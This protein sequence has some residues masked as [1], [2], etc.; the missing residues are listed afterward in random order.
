MARRIP[1]WLRELLKV[2]AQYLG[3]GAASIPA[4]VIYALLLQ[5]NM[6]QNIALLIAVP[7]GVIF[8]YFAWNAI[9]KAINLKVS[10]KA[11]AMEVIAVGDQYHFIDFGIVAQRQGVLLDEIKRTVATFL[12]TAMH[13]EFLAISQPANSKAYGKVYTSAVDFQPGI[14][15]R[16]SVSVKVAGKPN[17]IKPIR[18]FDTMHLVEPSCA[19]NTNQLAL[20]A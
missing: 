7:I 5:W 13:E 4:G 3:V 19:A 10:S 15:G 17:S 16:Y 2:W 11:T 1:Y 8:A 12:V 18:S 9:D 14:V 6:A 20:A